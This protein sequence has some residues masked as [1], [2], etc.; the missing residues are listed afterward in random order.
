MSIPPISAFNRGGSTGLVPLH[1]LS[2]EMTGSLDGWGASFVVC[3]PRNLP[4]LLG[5]S[6]GENTKDLADV[7]ANLARAAPAAVVIRGLP[8]GTPAST[9]DEWE[10][11]LWEP[12]LEL[13]APQSWSGSSSGFPRRAKPLPALGADAVFD[14]TGLED[15]FVYRFARFCVRSLSDSCSSEQLLIA[16]RSKCSP[17]SLEESLANVE[18]CTRVGDLAAGR[19]VARFLVPRGCAGGL[20]GFEGPGWS[21]SPRSP[22]K[23]SPASSS[24]ASSSSASGPTPPSRRR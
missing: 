10:A 15:G 3:S 24:S 7:K 4:L 14:G 8:P 1:S 23:S 20:V 17:S 2:T 18:Y 9:S 13:R 5:R 19:A 11:P 21:S 6:C 16:S 22:P 12:S